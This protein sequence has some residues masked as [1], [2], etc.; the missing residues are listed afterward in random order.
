M[1]VSDAHAVNNRNHTQLLIIIFMEKLCLLGHEA[2]LFSEID[3]QDI[4]DI[5]P[6]LG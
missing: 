3:S 6:K 4:P 2:R 1:S 5:E